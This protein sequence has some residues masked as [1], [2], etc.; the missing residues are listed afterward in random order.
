MADPHELNRVEKPDGFD[1]QLRKSSVSLREL[2]PGVFSVRYQGVGHADF[3][4][5]LQRALDA[6]IRKGLV[7][8]L[9]VDASELQGYESD[10]RRL[11]TTW[12]TAQRGNYHQVPILFRSELVK[13]GINLVNPL[14]GNKIL[15]L[16]ERA[17]YDEVV[18][19]AVVR[20]RG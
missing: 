11:W 8:A 3:V 1:L 12:F 15:A 17:K 16:T 5:Q 19:K 2:A 13:M 7:V 18:Q 6:R 20:A 14:I 10:F 4:P 9:C